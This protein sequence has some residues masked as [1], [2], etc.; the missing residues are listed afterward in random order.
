MSGLSPSRA[1]PKAE[2]AGKL[3]M[4]FGRFQSVARSGQKSLAQ[5]SP[6]FTLGY[7]PTEMSPEGA[8]RYGG[9]R[10]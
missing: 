1:A 10:L 9:N 8:G 7:P 6:G 3:S 4:E 5:G 2:G